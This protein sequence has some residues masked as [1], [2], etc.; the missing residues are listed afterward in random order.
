[1]TEHD[2]ESGSA[3]AITD[4]GLL[5]E[6][7]RMATLIP[8]ETE[9][10]MERILA[11]VLNAATWDDL[12]APWETSKAEQLAGKR[13]VFDRLERRPSDFREGLGIFLVCHCHDYDNGDVIV[14]TTSAIGVIGQLVRAYALGAMPIV[15][16]FIIAERATK[17]GYRPHHLKMHGSLARQNADATA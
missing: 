16:E 12:D 5:A 3:I 8:M 10:G 14:V 9:G 4:K 13:L 11:Q 7:A 1:M 15:A 2:G 6:F 17:G